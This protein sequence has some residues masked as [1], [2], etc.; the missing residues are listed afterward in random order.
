MHNQ[1]KWVVALG[2]IPDR[3][4]AKFLLHNF[5]KKKKKKSLTTE[6][7]FVSHQQKIRFLEAKNSGEI[8][9]SNF[10]QKYSFIETFNQISNVV[11]MRS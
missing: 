8:S 10:Q 9:R 11:F 5:A 1:S 4:Y 3:S 6:N 7:L 2:N